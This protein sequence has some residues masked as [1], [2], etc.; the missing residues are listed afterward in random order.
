MDQSAPI[1]YE[2]VCPPCPQINGKYELN[3]QRTYYKHENGKVFLMKHSTGQW[4]IGDGTFFQTLTESSTSLP[5]DIVRWK[6]LVGERYNIFDR[7]VVKP[8]V[9]PAGIFDYLPLRC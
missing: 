8:M 2:V 3:P 7:M 1:A 9:A 6:Y 5:S 4:G